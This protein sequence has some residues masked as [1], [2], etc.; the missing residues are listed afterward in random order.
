MGKQLSVTV[1]II[2]LVKVVMPIAVIFKLCF[3][4]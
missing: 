1:T 2:A 3:H 4:I